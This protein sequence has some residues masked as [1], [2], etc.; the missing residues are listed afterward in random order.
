MEGDVNLFFQKSF[1]EI[2]AELGRRT[3]SIEGHNTI[4]NNERTL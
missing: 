2:L 4:M 3:F 1:D